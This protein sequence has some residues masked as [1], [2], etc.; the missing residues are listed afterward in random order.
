LALHAVPE[1]VNWRATGEPIAIL[2]LR[3]G[4]SRV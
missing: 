2:I 4:L 3:M 1:R